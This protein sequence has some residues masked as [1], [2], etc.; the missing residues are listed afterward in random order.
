MREDDDQ[1]LGVLSPEDGWLDPNSVLQG[2]RK[3]ALACGV[4]FIKD[5]VVDLYTRGKRIVEVELASGARLQADHIINAA[6][7]WAAS[8]TACRVP[9]SRSPA[10]ANAATASSFSR[11]AK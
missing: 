2:F 9:S 4:E 11:C 8:P 10:R 1:A 6:G 5:R 3:K 7:C